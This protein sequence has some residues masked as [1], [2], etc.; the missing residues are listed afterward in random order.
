MITRTKKKDLRLQA[1]ATAII[2]VAAISPQFAVAQDEASADEIIVTGSRIPS[3]NAVATSPVTTIGNVEFDIRGT[4]RVED[5]VNTLPQAFAAQG[6]NTSN[7]ATGT[8]QVSLRGLGANRTLVLVDGRRLQYGAPISSAPD[9]NQIPSALVERVDILT[10]GASAVYGSDAIAGVVNFIMIKDFEGVRIDGQLSGYQHSNNNEDAQAILA[11]RNFAPPES[12]VFDGKGQELTLIVGANSEDGRGNVTAYAGYRNNDAI[13]QADRDYS[14]CAYGGG[15]FTPS[16]PFGFACGGSA[17]SP[18]GTFATPTGTF[19]LDENG[20]GNT[21]RPSDVFVNPTS[22]D[23]YNFAPT[24]F[25]QRPDERYTLGAFA[26]YEIN[27][28]ADVYSQAMFYDYHSDAQ[29]AYSGTFFVPN[30]INCDNPL[31][32]AQQASIIC[33]ANAGLPVTA[34][35]YPGKRLVEGLPRNFNL[36]MQSFRIVS[37]VRGEIADGWNYDAFFQ[38]G[39]SHMASQFE[40]DVSTTRL[41]R[42]LDV[43]D[44][45]GVPTCRSVVDGTDPNCVPFNMFQIGGVTPAAVAYVSL[46]SFQDGN[47]YQYM[48]QI[49]LTGD[50]GQYGL[51]SPWAE[52]GI[53]IAGGFEWRKDGLDF[54]PDAL[55]QSGDLAGQGGTTPPTKGTIETTDFFVEAEIPLISGQSF[56]ELLKFNGGYRHSDVSTS[57]SYS[58]WKLQG[59]WQ[60]TPDIRVRGGWQRAARAAN[61]IEAFSPQS[62][63][64]TTLPTLA[65][66]QSDPCAGPVPLAT[67][68]QCANTGVMAGQYGSI[69]SSPA[70]QYNAVFGGNP[71]LAPEV[72]DTYT[73]GGVL[74]PEFVPGNLFL[75]VDYFDITVD[76]FVGTITANT[77]LTNCLDSGDPTFCNLITRDGAGS[78]WLQPSGRFLSTNTNTGSLATSGL[79]INGNYSFDL[80]EIGLG[81][82]GGLSFDFVGTYLLSYDI[83]ELPGGPVVACEGKYA[84]TCSSLAAGGPLPAWRHKL[85][86]TWQTPIGVDASVT[87]RMF[88]SVD[89]FGVA[90]PDPSVNRNHTLDG[91]HYIDVAASYNVTEKWNVRVGV[92][93]LLDKDPPLTSQT[94]GFAN[95]NTYPQTYDAQGRYLFVG[96]TIDF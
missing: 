40:N 13:L 44:V 16:R 87:W 54:R 3:A 30:S 50:L 83:Q 20:P 82:A 56:A 68:A 81:S 36:R 52:S 2:A 4:T 64:L 14:A 28:H 6:A 90:A 25:Y 91:R 47:T 31:M 92:N 88:S 35:L 78:L 77:A 96:T 9:L 95:G 65:N 74:T 33:G 1:S 41:L 24:N 45:G 67:L 70:Q 27:E 69:S 8:A 48:G 34:T 94:A 58:T 86:T 11:A 80:D 62:T 19:T 17:T 72:S 26:H 22:A 5:L 12:G 61:V 89:Q 75:S 51:K 73:V 21:F 63:G 29:I 39:N 76:G 7:G 42:A 85:R 59:D 43:I 15:S 60:L 84:G 38:Y 71:N 57:G 23:A 10:G 46:P 18:N 79:D 32:S 55:F 53:G 37:G 49:S 93:N 66:G